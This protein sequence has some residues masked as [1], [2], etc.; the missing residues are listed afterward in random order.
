VSTSETP[1]LEQPKQLTA[2][3][4]DTAKLV[5]PVLIERT[6]PV[7]PPLAKAANVQGTIRLKVMVNKEGIVTDSR[8]ISGP[9]LLAGAAASAVHDWKYKPATTDGQPIECWLPVEIRF[10]LPKQPSVE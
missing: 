2:P 4:G 8:L 5:Q 10:T 3:E 1:T 9:P 6:E 7:Y